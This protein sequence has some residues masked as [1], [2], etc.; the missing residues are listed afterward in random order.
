VLGDANIEEVAT[1]NSNDRPIRNSVALLGLLALGACTTLPVTVDSNP[2]AS[3]GT[4]HTYVFA[5]EHVSSPGQPVGAYGN[6]LNSDRLRAAIAANMAARGIQPG[7][8]DAA[9]CVVGYAI[10]SRVVA[11]EFAGWGFGWGGGWRGGYGGM[12]Y[13][14]PP[15]RNEGRI[16]IDLFEAR[17]RQAI[18]HASVNQDVTD[19]TGPNAE[20][21]INEAASAIFSKFPTPAAMTI[22]PGA[23]PVPA[24]KAS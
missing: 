12:G 13:D 15:V 18:W 21:R 4:C 2:N 17:N 22:A 9:D 8:G 7:S 24:A 10:G 16:S 6:P 23:A 14:W 19:L 11:D 20:R 3:V 5:H 1:M